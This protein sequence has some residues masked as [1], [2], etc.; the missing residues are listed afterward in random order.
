MQTMLEI[1]GV[2]AAERG[3][4]KTLALLEYVAKRLMADPNKR[5][6]ILVLSQDVAK[7]TERMFKGLFPKFP[8]NRVPYFHANPDSFRQQ[9]DEVYI[10]EPW[11]LDIQ[12]LHMLN[13]I[14]VFGAIGSPDLLEKDHY[15][16]MQAA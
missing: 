14:P 12:R 13:S 11:A 7:H 8:P 4:G 6:G 15:K 3:A 9:V 5:I 2:V 16:R 10:D 1:H